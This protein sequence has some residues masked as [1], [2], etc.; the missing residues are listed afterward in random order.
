MHQNVHCL[1]KYCNI[2]YLCL[3]QLYPQ[4]P[5][6]SRN[7]VQCESHS[8]GARI[9]GCH[10]TCA[11]VS[12]VRKVFA[13]DSFWQKQVGC[14]KHSHG[15]A[16]CAELLAAFVPLRS[17]DWACLG[18]ALQPG[19]GGH[20]SKTRSAEMSAQWWI[21]I[22]CFGIVALGFVLQ[23]KRRSWMFAVW[24]PKE[25][26]HEWWYSACAC[27]FPNNWWLIGAEPK[28]GA[29]GLTPHVVCVMAPTSFV[30][31][32]CWKKTLKEKMVEERLVWIWVLTGVAASLGKFSGNGKLKRGRGS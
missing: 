28:G 8:A 12:L 27:A 6:R 30:K 32:G 22:C 9:S 7:L 16:G 14:H 5:P 19:G 23:R 13:S 3:C 29:E 2:S 15:S 31:M 25:M 18:I 17:W 10:F 11:K 21:G 1:S 26:R 20:W 24:F 4:E